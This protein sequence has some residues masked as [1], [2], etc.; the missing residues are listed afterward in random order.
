MTGKGWRTFKIVAMLLVVVA[1][2]SAYCI[3][4]YDEVRFWIMLGVTAAVSIAYLMLF[5]RSEDNLHSFVSEMKTQ[6]NLTERDSLYKFPAPAVIVDK[7]GVIIWFNKAFTENIHSEDA[8]GINIESIVDIDLTDIMSQMDTVVEYDTGHYRVR[9]VTTAKKAEDDTSLSE[10]TLLYFQ[11][12]SEL[13]ELREEFRKSRSRV[14]LIMI[15]NIED[16][17]DSKDSDKG[18]ITVLIDKLIEDFV[19]SHGG[20]VR[21]SIPDKY[22]A[23]I[24]EEEITKLEQE[25]FKSIIEKAHEIT[26]ADRYPLTLSIGIGRGG[27]TLLESEKIA[28]SALD[29]TQG[30]GG[31]QVAIKDDNGYTFFGGSSQGMGTNSKVKTRIF[32]TS[33]LNLVQNSSNTIIMGHSWGDLDAIGAAAGVAAAVRGVGCRGYI[34]SNVE[35]TLALPIITRLKENLSGGGDLFIDEETA[36]SMLDES[37]LLVIVDTN[38]K[39]MLDSKAIY[40][41]AKKVVYIDHHRQ[42]VNSIDNAMLSLHEPYAS[43]A[44]EI[45]AE[46]IQYFP[47]EEKP[48][49]YYADAMLSGI[50]LDTKNFVM[51]TDVRTFEAAAYLKS[52]NADTVA[53]KL[54]FANTIET[55][56]IRSRF[57]TTVQIYKQCAIAVGTE[58]SPQVRVAASQAADEMLNIEG[59]D[60]S[61]VVFP[62]DTGSN[63]SARSYGRLNVQLVMEKMGGGGHLTMS[64][65]QLPGTSVEEAK[66]MLM[67]AI[68]SFMDKI[69]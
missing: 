50:M 60:A 51:K 42:V 68:D 41:K 11:D 34:Y 8:Y 5:R 23:V 33:L 3:F 2:F 6:L 62:S 44:C 36:L 10:L 46:V 49:S 24:S 19:E 52:L 38:S 35:K 58:V 63:I 40:E 9:A 65:V 22:L 54:L 14:M 69:S 1:L 32:A 45:V 12:I 31:D 57:I 47:L 48:E 27:N 17:L 61:F 25:E 55:E 37:A 28:K 30:R 66:R 59:V 56:R 20:V 43:S 18:H 7:D 4:P 21:K 29:I 53:V 26:I 67:A 16:A 39:D 13:T 15:D 64:A